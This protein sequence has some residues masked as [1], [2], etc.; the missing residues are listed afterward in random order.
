MF[1]YSCRFHER[2][3]VKHIVASR[4]AGGECADGS[5]QSILKI[6]GLRRPWIVERDDHVIGYEH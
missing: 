5:I 2:E 3:K 1:S 4:D 6:S